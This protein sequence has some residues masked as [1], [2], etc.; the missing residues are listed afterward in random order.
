MFKKSERLTKRQFDTYFKS[1]K[2]FHFPHCTIV[3]SPLEALHV[4]V[5]A[6]KKLSKRA[7][8]RNLFRRRVYALLRTGLKKDSVSGVFIVLLKPTYATLP[9]KTAAEEIKQNIAAVIK[10]T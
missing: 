8:K 1:G 10:K 3:H 9:R 7:V 6:G 5:V 2:R 4:S